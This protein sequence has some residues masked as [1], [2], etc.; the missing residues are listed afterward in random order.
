[1]RAA[2]LSGG[3]R[4]SASFRAS[5]RA[6]WSLLLAAAGPALATAQSPASPSPPDVLAFADSLAQV[7]DRESLLRL[8]SQLIERARIERDDV[9]LHLRLGFLALQLAAVSGGRH[10]DDAGSEFEWALELDPESAL[11][12]YGLGLAERGLAPTFYNSRA[13]AQAML[14]K[15]HVAL[16]GRAFGR[17][18]ALEPGFARAALA[19]GELAQMR[20][21]RDERSAALRGLRGLPPEAMDTTTLLVR[22]RLERRL[23]ERDSAVATFGRYLAA[24]G[25]SALGL[26]ERARTRFAAGDSAG[27][28]DYRA[29]AELASG[30]ALLGYRADLAFIAPESALA[31]FDRTDGAARGEWLERFWSSRDLEG[32]RAEGERVAEHYQRLELALGDFALPPFTRRFGFEQYFRSGRVDVD[33]RGVIWVRH[34]AP[35]HRIVTV[36]NQAESWYYSPGTAE[37]LYFHFVA[38]EDLDDYRLVPSPGSVPLA[39]REDLMSE[40]GPASRDYWR[41]A[42]SGDARRLMLE[43]EMFREGKD[44]MVLG[45]TT[46]THARRWPA[47]LEA[48]RQAVATAES[49]DRGIVHLAVAV[50]LDDLP[51]EADRARGLRLRVVARSL[52]NGEVT[53]ADTT[54]PV[55]RGDDARFA[56]VLVDLG[57]AA[58]PVAVA[59]TAELGDSAGAVAARDTLQVPALGARL[60]L[61]DLM[62]GRESLGLHWAAGSGEPVPLNPLGQ[63]PRPEPLS[64]YYEVYGLGDAAG[65]AELVLW[66]VEG[67]DPPTDSLPPAGR[68]ALRLRFDE[69]GAGLVTRVR[70]SVDISDLPPGSYR[71]RLRLED[72]SGRLAVRT[73]RLEVTRK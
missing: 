16:A 33:D 24:G 48:S 44:M 7:H 45:T 4:V 65:A 54:V 49:G 55:P 15:D 23:G 67:G 35:S 20:S 66:R 60:A 52:A 13:A 22:G 32:L 25:D 8:E 50:P 29:G 11:A 68:R 38:G 71:L 42:N 46:D 31:E 63:H 62:L 18:M 1:M 58:G 41:L 30:E 37:E 73:A 56:M 12:W 6:A 3:A 36:R 72:A 64:V 70:R 21:L 10:W 34:G 59:A 40:G 5:A 26:L 14:G 39:A 47:V 43:Q 17:A 57:V 51:D 2:A 28:A 19:W 27:A 69:R 53:R 9:E 61:S